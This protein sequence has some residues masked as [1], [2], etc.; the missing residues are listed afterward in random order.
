[1]ALARMLCM[2]STGASRWGVGATL[3]ARGVFGAPRSRA[4]ES[5]MGPPTRER[6]IFSP[7]ICSRGAASISYRF[8]QLGIWKYAAQRRL[9]SDHGLRH[10]TCHHEVMKANLHDHG[11]DRTK[12]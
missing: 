4:P 12:S 5:E 10:H 7:P 3:G 1:M 2:R 9:V 6:L 11:T 8:G